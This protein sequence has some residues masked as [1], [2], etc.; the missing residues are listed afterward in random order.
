M[1]AT[2]RATANNILNRV[3]PEVG[4]PADSNPFESTDQ[5]YIQ[6]K[7]LLNIAGDDLADLWNWQFLIATYTLPN[8]SGDAGAYEFPADYLRMV[9]QTQWEATT[10]RPLSGPL[11]PQEWQLLTNS[12]LGSV[13]DVSFRLRDGMIHISPDTVEEGDDITFEY[14][15]R[16][17]AIDSS[18]GT[19]PISECVNGGDIVLYDRNLI[20]RMLK[21]KWLEAKNFDTTKAQADL[22]QTFALLTSSDK[23][24]PVLNAAGSRGRMF[25]NT[26]N[27]PDTGYGS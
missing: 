14:I 3:G 6:M 18:N 4:L 24:A 10:Q 22:N 11:S 16:N 15:S 8:G 19:T 26:W 25:I 7:T 5:N 13:L 23:G 21:V 27:A 1:T 9:N 17:W 2:R 20:S 12:S